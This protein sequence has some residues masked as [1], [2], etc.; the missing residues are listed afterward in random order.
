[1]EP[2]QA[3]EQFEAALEDGSDLTGGLLKQPGCEDAP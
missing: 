2:T 3:F 1:M